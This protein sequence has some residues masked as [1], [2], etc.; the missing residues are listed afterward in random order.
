MDNKL[1]SVNVSVLEVR[2][3]P[4]KSSRISLKRNTVVKHTGDNK[5]FRKEPWIEVQ[6][7][8]EPVVIGYVNRKYLNEI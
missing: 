5:Q 3:V 4:S 2:K 1:Y 6:T 7:L 8:S